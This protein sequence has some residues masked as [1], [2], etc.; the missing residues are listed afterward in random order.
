VAHDGAYPQGSRGAHRLGKPVRQERPKVRRGPTPTNPRPGK[1][2]PAP[3]SRGSS[4]RQDLKSKAPAEPDAPDEA[5]FDESAE[6]KLE[7]R[8]GGE[9]EWRWT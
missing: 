5:S 2:A 7:R 3:V 9:G 1:T 4:A 6:A 8:Y